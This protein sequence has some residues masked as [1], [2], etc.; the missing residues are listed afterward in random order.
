MKTLSAKKISADI[1]ESKS[2]SLHFAHQIR[3]HYL[4]ELKEIYSSRSKTAKRETDFNTILKAMEDLKLF[5]KQ[6]GRV[7]FSGFENIPENIYLHNNSKDI[8]K[9][10]YEHIRKFAKHK[11][12]HN[13]HTLDTTK[14]SLD[15]EVKL[16][17]NDNFVVSLRSRAIAR[18]VLPI[19]S[20]VSGQDAIGH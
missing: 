4:I 9:W 13:D 10:C 6:E 1:I 8:F 12:L 5:Q 16:D 11:H 20:E 3:I 2:K 7:G 18:E 15:L 17:E 19:Q 14:Q